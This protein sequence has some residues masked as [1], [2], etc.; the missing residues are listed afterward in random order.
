MSQGQLTLTFAGLTAT[1]STFSEGNFPRT[2][3]ETPQITLSRNGAILRDGTT[4]EPPHVW[5]I[6]TVV[7]RHLRDIL[8]AMHGYAMSTPGSVLVDDE[9]RLFSESSPR[10]RAIVP[11]TSEV[12]QGLAVQYYSRF[13]AEFQGAFE[14]SQNS[15]AAPESS[16]VLAYIATFQLRE[17]TKVAA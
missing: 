7:N 16:D 13:N 9:I 5:Q 10:T 4:Y 15:S 12:T 17:T 8:E 6:V 14:I 11:S 3:I 2:R 1:L